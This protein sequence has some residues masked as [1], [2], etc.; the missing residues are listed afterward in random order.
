M[1]TKLV[2]LDSD[3]PAF[4]SR[5]TLTVET[6]LQ[7]LAAGAGHGVLS[8]ACTGLLGPQ[9]WD[10]LSRYIPGRISQNFVID[11]LINGRMAWKSFS[12]RISGDYQ[13]HYGNNPGP[14]RLLLLEALR[15]GGFF[16]F[17]WLL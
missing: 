10:I 8:V 9:L 13:L 16:F 15:L 11:L 7:F 5:L 4:A 2:G 12:P 1:A 6:C 3:H 14:S 17:K